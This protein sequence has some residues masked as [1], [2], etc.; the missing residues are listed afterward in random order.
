MNYT[1][2]VVQK[3]YPTTYESP[4]IVAENFLLTHMIVEIYLSKKNIKKSLG[5]KQTVVIVVSRPDP[6]KT[7]ECQFIYTTSCSIHSLQ[8]SDSRH[9]LFNSAY[10]N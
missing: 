10:R 9:A 3:G 5:D 6:N 7:S 4:K 2:N 1:N 8:Y